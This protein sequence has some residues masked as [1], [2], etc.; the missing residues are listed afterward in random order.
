MINETSRDHE[1]VTH[2]EFQHLYRYDG[3]KMSQPL[4]SSLLNTKLRL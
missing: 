2:L 3:A 1:R 4:L